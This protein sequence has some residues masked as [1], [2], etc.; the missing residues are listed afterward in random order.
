MTAV[1][2][3]A[4]TTE[5]AWSIDGVSLHQYGWNVATVGGSRYDLPPRRG[6]NIKFSY[7]PGAIH[8]PKVVDSRTIN[9]VMWVTGVDPATG[10]AA[11]DP[12]LRWNDSWD[13]LRRL[14]WKPNGAQVTLT[15][16]WKLTVDG[17]PTIVTADAQAEI[18]DTMSPTMTGRHRAEFTMTL[19]LADPF[20][21]GPEISVPLNLGVPVSVWNPGHDV[22][23]HGGLEVDFIGKLYSPKLTNAT[24]TPDVW[25]KYN[26]LVRDSPLQ[27]LNLKVGTFE[28]TMTPVIPTGH[29][30]EWLG[31]YP[32][33]AT[34]P[35]VIGDIQ[36]AGAKHWMGL[37]LGPNLLTLTADAG[38]T[39]GAVLRFRPPYV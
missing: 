19:L 17:Q 32:K 29:A 7:R 9:L 1:T 10:Q 5:E 26:N 8:R 11:D 21:Y 35:N 28:A 39:G 36:H 14:V 2:P 15:R 23:A 3:N 20:F 34:S 38:S 13:F 22:A 4:Q 24:P 6:D 18:A 31:R 30:M 33:A 27:T 37:N 12:T 16:R 25:V